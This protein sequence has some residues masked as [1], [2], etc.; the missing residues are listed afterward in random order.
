MSTVNIKLLSPVEITKPNASKQYKQMVVTHTDGKD[1]TGKKIFDFTTP[2]HVWDTLAAAKQGDTFLITREKNDKGYW[3][4]KDIGPAGDPPAQPDP[5]PKSAPSAT[6]PAKVG[7]WETSDERA[8]KQVYIVRQSTIN[9]A[10]E[11]LKSTGKP[12]G[13][14][15]VKNLAKQYEDYVFSDGVAGLTDDQPE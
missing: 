2:K 5:N 11:T 1:T 6:V 14:D 9:A 12:F 3:E 4:W 15:A 10:I 8:K 13:T 7:N